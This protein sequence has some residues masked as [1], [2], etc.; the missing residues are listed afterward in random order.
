MA[1]WVNRMIGATRLD[2][3]TYEEVKADPKATVQA[4][5]V[6]LLSAVAS[7]IGALRV[8]THYAF[9]ASGVISALG[10]ALVAWV[11]LVLL[12]WLIG[13]KCLAEAETKAD[14]GPLIRTTGFAASPSILSALG[15]IPI[16]GP[17]INGLASLWTLATMVVAVRQAFNYRS[18]GRAILVCVIGAV[19]LFIIYALYALIAMLSG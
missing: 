19:V 10:I 12:T 6:V 2:V 18:T 7:G 8:G 5:A 15:W 13:T 4:I 9:S 16:L 3:A 1:S 14:L 11:A 17:V